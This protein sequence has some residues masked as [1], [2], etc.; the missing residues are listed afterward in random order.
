MALA[1]KRK[2]QF[3]DKRTVIQAVTMSQIG[4]TAATS[5]W[6]SGAIKDILE[7]NSHF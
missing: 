2:T 3:G 1:I 7:G 4:K 5:A 6:A